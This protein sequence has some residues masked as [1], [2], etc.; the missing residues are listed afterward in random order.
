MTVSQALMPKKELRNPEPQPKGGV[1][2]GGQTPIPSRWVGIQRSQWMAYDGI[3]GGGELVEPNNLQISLGHTLHT[4]VIEAEVCVLVSKLQ[5][6]VQKFLFRRHLWKYGWQVRVALNPKSH[7]E[8]HLDNAA[9]VQLSNVSWGQNQT[10]GCIWVF[11]THL[12]SPRS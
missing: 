9:T 1:G 7:S 3:R 4:A 6:K 5:T 2:V 8:G 12:R 11:G 10:G